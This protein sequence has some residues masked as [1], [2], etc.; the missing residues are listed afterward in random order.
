M[1]TKRPPN[2]K[3]IAVRINSELRE[4][5]REFVSATDA[6]SES[7]VLRYIISRFFSEES[8]H[9]VDKEETS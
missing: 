2:N 1:Q 6:V 9:E 7:E 4:K 5:I 3:T 8:Q